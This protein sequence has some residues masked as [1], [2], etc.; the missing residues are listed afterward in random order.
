[1]VEGFCRC[2]RMGGRQ[3][4]N[5]QQTWSNAHAQGIDHGDG[6]KEELLISAPR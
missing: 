3:Q 1:M 5:K 2:T 4:K 6:L